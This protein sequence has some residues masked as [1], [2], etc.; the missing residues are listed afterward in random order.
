MHLMAVSVFWLNENLPSQPF[1]LV[2]CFN[3]PHRVTPSSQTATT[4]K[5]VKMRQR[6]LMAKK[7]KLV[8]KVCRKETAEF[9]VV[10]IKC[11]TS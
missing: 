7:T 1:S 10:P 6:N 9:S 5:E 3:F 4:T 2:F 8:E 11:Y